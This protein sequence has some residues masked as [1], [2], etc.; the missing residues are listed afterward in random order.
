VVQ[1]KAPEQADPERL[2]DI[3]TP[4]AAIEPA[5]TGCKQW[6]IIKQQIT[7]KLLKYM[8]HLRNAPRQRAK[9]EPADQSA[10]AAPTNE[11]TLV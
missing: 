11:V 10:P 9:R 7:G 5:P 1:S 4:N 3:A 6:I 8:A 2:A